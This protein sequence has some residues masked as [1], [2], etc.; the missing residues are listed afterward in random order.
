MKTQ[1]QD[2]ATANMKLK[3]ILG[4]DKSFSV[5]M[6][7]SIED[8]GGLIERKQSGSVNASSAIRRQVE[9]RAVDKD[10]NHQTIPSTVKR[11]E[12]SI[13]KWLREGKAV[14]S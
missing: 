6:Q 10:G 5:L 7:W 11:H 2:K 13:A 14:Q 3:L 4:K 12:K 1:N 9:W 8:Y